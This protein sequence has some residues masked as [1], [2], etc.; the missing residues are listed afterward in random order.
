MNELRIH[1]KNSDRFRNLHPSDPLC[2][3]TASYEAASEFMENEVPDVSEIVSVM[4]DLYAPMSEEYGDLKKLDL[5]E[6]EAI[7]KENGFDFIN[8]LKM[9]ENSSQNYLGGEIIGI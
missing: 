6:V 3:I 5:A 4:H 8:H 2:L 7:L 1:Q 9:R